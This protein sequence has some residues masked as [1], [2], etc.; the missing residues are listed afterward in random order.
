MKISI[1][2]V[3]YNGEK[4]IEDCIQSVLRQTHDDIEYI[5]VDGLS[6]DSTMEIVGRYKDRISKIISEKDK[7]IY[8]AM[9]KGI[10]AATGDVIAFLN[11]DDFYAEDNV[12]ECA[13]KSLEESGAESVYGSLVYVEANNIQKP[14]RLWRAPKRDT[15][16]FFNGNF[17]PHPTFMVKKE[18]YDKLGLFREDLRL[19][20]DFEIMLRF[21]VVG[22]ITSCRLNKIMVIMRFSGASNSS[23]KGI[24]TSLSECYKA[25]KKHNLPVS[26]LFYIKTLLVRA[27]QVP[28]ARKVTLVGKNVNSA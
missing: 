9:N 24:L 13:V 1:I 26:P 19:S 15:A 25:F 16:M 4:H 18:V 8:D 22:N 5:V 3:V 28:L 2:T 27:I 23:I 6:T 10:K 11:A 20:A 12:V 14:M 7:G 21:L 17:P